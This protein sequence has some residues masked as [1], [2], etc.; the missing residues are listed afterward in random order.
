MGQK[1]VDSLC[2]YRYFGLAQCIFPSLSLFCIN[3]FFSLP[4]CV[5]SHE[6]TGFYFNTPQLLTL[7]ALHMGDCRFCIRYIVV[8]N[9]LFI[10]RIIPQICLQ[11]RQ[12]SQSSH[13]FSSSQCTI[14]SPFLLTFGMLFFNHLLISFYHCMYIAY[15]AGQEYAIQHP[16]T[17]YLQYIQIHSHI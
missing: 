15:I 6:F 4:C 17:M 9:T 16:S 12:D 13:T 3:T 2:R 1:N 11:N 8:F 10:T 14:T 5:R 7:P